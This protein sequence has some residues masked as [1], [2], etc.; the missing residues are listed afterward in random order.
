MR[1]GMSPTE[2]CEDTIRHMAR[3]QPHAMDMACVVFAAGR[4]GNYGAAINSGK[5]HLWAC[6]DGTVSVQLYKGIIH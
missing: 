1:R 4:A 6:V 3:R 5:F 2:A